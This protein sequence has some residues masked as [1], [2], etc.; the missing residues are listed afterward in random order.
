MLIFKK[1]ES[2]LGDMFLDRID[3]AVIDTCITRWTMEGKPV[4]AIM[5]ASGHHRLSMHNAYVNA[6]E[7]HLREAFCLQ[8]VY[9]VNRLN[10]IAP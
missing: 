10:L 6:Q 8:G 7:H 1:L 4:G 5:A 9:T 3:E 2:R